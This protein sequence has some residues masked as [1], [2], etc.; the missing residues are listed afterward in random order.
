MKSKRKGR[1]IALYTILV[2]VALLVFYV[3][4][5]GPVSCGYQLSFQV[6]PHAARTVSVNITHDFSYGG[7]P[8]LYGFAPDYLN[9]LYYP[10]VSCAVYSPAVMYVLEAY[11]NLW[12]RTV[13]QTTG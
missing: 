12:G 10:L 3:L 1:N 11:L 7:N 6:T 13:W 4:S 5:I 9:T 2:A 8:S